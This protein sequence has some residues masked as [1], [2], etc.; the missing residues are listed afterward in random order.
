M[1][2]AEEE[3]RGHHPCLLIEGAGQSGEEVRSREHKESVVSFRATQRGKRMLVPSGQL[4]T[5]AS[6]QCS[7]ASLTTGSLLA[8][9]CLLGKLKVPA[10]I[11]GDT[12]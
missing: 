1:L 6:S 10:K 11:C 4:K 5:V 9:Y 7:E 8:F 2:T 3:E 12:N